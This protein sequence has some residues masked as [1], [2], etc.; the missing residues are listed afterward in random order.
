MP[1]PIDPLIPERVQVLRKTLDY[2]NY[3]YY[4]LDDPEIS[5]AAYDRLMAELL[6]LEA[7][8]PDLVTTDSPSQRVGAPPLAAFDSIDHSLPMLSLDN[9]FCEEDIH[10]FD[11]RVR[12][13]L[14]TD[15]EILYTA[16]PKLDGLAVELVY[17]N[18]RL[19][20]AATRGDGVR[21]E[22]I[23]ANVRTIRSVP[24]S[25]RAAEGQPLPTR[26]EVRGEVFINLA[27]FHALNAER[28]RQDQSPFANPRNAAAGS[29]RQLDS[30]ITA[31]RPLEIY[32]YGVGQTQPEFEHDSHWVSLEQ[33]KSLGL[34]INPLIRPCISIKDAL[35]FYRE[36]V[37][38][39][40]QLPY[41]IDGMVIKVDRLSHQDRLGA[42]SRSPRWAIAYK[43]QAVQETTRITAIEVQVGRTGALTPVA[44]LEPVS[45]GGVTV[46]RATLHN[47]DEIDK[48]DIRIG[49]TVLI[50]RAGDVIPEVVKVV[51]SART[52]GEAP[53]D[54]PTTCP[55]CSSRVVRIEG[56]AAT[57]CV[58]S[59]CPAQVKERI[60][61]FAAKAAF[62][63]DGL[64]RKLVDQ[65]VAKGLIGSCSDIFYLNRETLCG[66]DRMGEKSADN[67]LAAIER[68]KRVSLPRFLFGLGIRH[69]GEHAA[70]VLAERFQDLNQVAAA[71]IDTL[72]A[73]EAIGPVAARSVVEFFKTKENQEIIYR[74]MAGGVEILQTA[75]PLTGRLEDKVFVLTGTLEGCSRSEAK[76]R[77]EAAGG[78][79][80]NA[81]SRKTDYLVA[82]AAPGSK[83]ERAR[84]LEVAV[85]DKAGLDALLGK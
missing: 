36:L 9:G 37:D 76:K 58:N 4:A 61:H 26:L 30:R 54:M 1:K 18:G 84:N 59:S 34:R 14:S 73:I 82:G 60:R 19:T 79:V 81:V 15:E 52:G 20:A 51:M 67:L 68:S 5:D 24:L 6:A 2:H 21:G 27:G 23:T 22:L 78:R 17:E 63:I 64:G 31:G 8:W 39:R 46:S 40:H 85:I 29:L 45:V 80:V 75:A 72:E 50:Q 35:D 3:R 66:L 43:F 11:R 12:K 83:L 33:L 55:V 10:E 25:L 42:T 38:M 69:V 47:E 41:D 77:I 56:E 7:A 53:F 44:R 13:L 57:R 71:D 65:L 74:L 48:K 70:R 32:C 16:E 28:I 49:D 62:D